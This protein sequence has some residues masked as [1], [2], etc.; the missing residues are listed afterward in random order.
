MR[1]IIGI[2]VALAYNGM[3]AADAAHSQALVD[4]LVDKLVDALFHRAL[5]ARH[6]QPPGARYS[7][8]SHLISSNTRSIHTSPMAVPLLNHRRSAMGSDQ[9][10][11]LQERMSDQLDNE[12]A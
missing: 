4:S 12:E 8:G 6:L 3:A 1:Y 9:L 11:R 7:P 2:L 5:K 10:D